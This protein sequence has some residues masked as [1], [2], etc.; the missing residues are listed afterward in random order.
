ME[1]YKLDI[2]FLRKIALERGYCTTKVCLD[3]L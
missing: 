1:F 2:E 3:V